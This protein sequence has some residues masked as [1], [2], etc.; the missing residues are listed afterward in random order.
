MAGDAGASALMPPVWSR[1]AQND[2]FDIAGRYDAIDPALADAIVEQ[3]ETAVT[4]PDG[5][6]GRGGDVEQLAGVRRWQVPRTPFVLLYAVGEERAEVLRVIH[7]ASDW[8]P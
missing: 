4:R 7:A 3:L 2:V 6:V 5:F 1:D 8:R